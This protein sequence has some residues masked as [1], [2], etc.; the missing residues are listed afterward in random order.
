MSKQR[1]A[2]LAAVSGILWLAVLLHA[3]ST[4]RIVADESVHVPQIQSF[5]AGHFV[6]H[7]LLTTIPGYHLLVAALL[8]LFAADSVASMRTITAC[9]GIA[10]A[11]VFHRIRFDAGD[12]HPARSAALLFFLPILFPYYFLVYTDV[13][14]LLAVLC[15][16]LA[17][18]KERHVI[19][20]GALVLALL[21]RQNNVV[22]AAF[23]PAFALWPALRQPGWRQRRRAGEIVRV[24][25]PYAIPVCVFFGYWAW[26]G[27]ISLSKT[28][29][30][31]H[32]DLKL[33][34][35]NLYFT[36]FLFM[37][38]F[39]DEVWRGVKRFGTRLRGAPWWW[40][41]PLVVMVAATR[42]RGS[43]DNTQ[44]TDYFIRNAIVQAV[45]DGGWVRWAFGAAVA[46]SAC[47][48]ASTRFVA[49]QAWLLYPFCAFYLAS[50]W[51]IE[52][53]YSIIPFA[54]WMALRAPGD[55]RADRVRLVAWASASLVFA[56]GIFSGA[57]ML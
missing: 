41:M 53:R 26:N 17:A 56:W 36:L 14:S 48:I 40:L 6:A 47:G 20:A 10:S 29:A 23:L 55:D 16:L 25:W 45:R 34:A 50:S 3:Q 4:D 11:M 37:V 22:W 15:A 38:F 43:Y 8:K 2:A 28:V 44:F 54:L 24:A 13:L 52:N 5:L 32:P 9:I 1:G 57:F 7:P 46:L 35:G 30:E 39:P 21:V 19:A 12:P 49:G 42:L 27:T 18:L 33:H 51:L 31:G